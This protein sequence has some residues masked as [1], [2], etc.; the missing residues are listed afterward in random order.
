MHSPNQTKIRR[1][2]EFFVKTVE[3]LDLKADNLHQAQLKGIQIFVR[4]L[5]ISQLFK[6][7]F[8]IF[9]PSHFPL[10]QE[11]SQESETGRN[12]QLCT[13]QGEAALE[14]HNT[15]AARIAHVRFL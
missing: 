6:C 15:R 14:Q 5:F 2:P 9:S 8:G 13:L 4:I 3:H 12:P 7:L 1:N 11:S 10:S